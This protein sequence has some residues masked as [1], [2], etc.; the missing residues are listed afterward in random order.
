M[1]IF[2]THK[3]E[4]RSKH[5]SFLI[6]VPFYIVTYVRRP[7]WTL[8]QSFPFQHVILRDGAGGDCILERI[9]REVFVLFHQPGVSE[10][11][12]YAYRRV[13]VEVWARVLLAPN[14]AVK[15]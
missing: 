1:A 8:D 3:D 4:L 2:P 7:L 6:S 11:M 5:S 15:V 14:I 12:M 13:A 9:R 10:A